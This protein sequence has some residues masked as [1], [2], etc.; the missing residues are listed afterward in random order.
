[1]PSRRRARRERN[2]AKKIAKLN[3]DS[4]ADESQD[5]CEERDS[6]QEAHEKKKACD[7]K[8]YKANS[9]SNVMQDLLVCAC[10]VQS[11]DGTF[12]NRLSHAHP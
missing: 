8:H 7:R 3:D 4:C 11:I 5:E 2:L 10:A 12:C 6:F 9:E 1:M